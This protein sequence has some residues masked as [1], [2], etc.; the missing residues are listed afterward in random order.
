MDGAHLEALPAEGG[1]DQK[2]QQAWMTNR[3]LWHAMQ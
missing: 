3:S 1:M 2:W